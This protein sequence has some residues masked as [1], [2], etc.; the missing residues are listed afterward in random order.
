MSEQ[1]SYEKIME[2]SKLVDSWLADEQSKKILEIRKQYHYEGKENLLP[3]LMKLSSSGVQ[4][5]MNTEF[6]NANTL[7]E[8]RENIENPVIF[9]GAGKFAEKIYQSVLYQKPFIAEKKVLFCDKNYESI[10]TFRGYPVISPKDLVENYTDSSVVIVS[11]KF[12]EEISEFL[13]K[14]NFPKS[15]IFLSRNMDDAKNQY[16]A[17]PFM[18]IGK[19]EVFV[20]GGTFNG[21]TSVEFSKRCEKQFEK[22]YLFE[23][24]Q[25]FYQLAIDN[26]EKDNIHP[27]EIF[28]T[29]LWDKKETLYFGGKGWGFGVGKG[30]SDIEIPV[31][32]LDNML[33]DTRVTFIKMDIEGAELKAIEGARN[34][35]TKYKPKLAIS[36]YHKPEDIYEIPMIVKD[37]VPEYKL[38]IRHYS[39]CWSETVLYAIYEG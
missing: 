29:G 20:D 38:Y 36:L 22:I 8:L 15:Q 6:K 1:L 19:E 4:D 5:L 9:Y 33:G 13:I 2:N 39:T 37:L 32:S 25:D 28:P 18:Q 3:E 34:I 14:E 24:S 26:L 30:N 12:E 23:P 21:F 11:R 31:D 10:G 27:Y 17:E 35:I 7:G 16:F